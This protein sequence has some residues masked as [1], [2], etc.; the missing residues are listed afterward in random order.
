[1][2]LK[3]A[4]HS[5][6]LPCILNSEQQEVTEPKH[7]DQVLNPHCVH[8]LVHRWKLAALKMLHQSHQIQH[9]ERVVAVVVVSR[10]FHS[11]TPI[12]K[13]RNRFHSN[14]YVVHLIG[15]KLIF[16]SKNLFFGC[17]YMK[18]HLFLENETYSTRITANPINVRWIKAFIEWKII[19]FSIIRLSVFIVVPA[20]FSPTGWRLKR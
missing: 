3:N 1:M 18:W 19:V 14:L 6:L 15:C 10:H 20:P 12:R 8:W 17:V 2:L 4:N 16:L 11:T 13:F 5:A 9:A 7:Q